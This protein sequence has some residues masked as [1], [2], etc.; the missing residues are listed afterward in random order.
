LSPAR[1]AAAGRAGHTLR[2][3]RNNMVIGSITTAVVY[4]VVGSTVVLGMLRILG[5][6]P[7]IVDVVGAC[8]AGALASLIPTVGGPVSLLVTLA[9]LYWRGVAELR[10]IAIA[11]VVARL[12]MVPALLVLRFAH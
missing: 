8:V 3:G 4:A 5:P 7:G 6:R 10:E 11:V 12:A 1:P 9:A 2:A